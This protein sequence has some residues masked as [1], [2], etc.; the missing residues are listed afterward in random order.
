MWGRD[1]SPPPAPQPL[2]TLSKNRVGA[3]LGSPQRTP[4]QGTSSVQMGRLKL[5]E[6]EG[7]TQDHTALW[8]A[9]PGLK[10]VSCFPI[11]FLSPGHLPTADSQPA[12]EC[13]CSLLNDF[14]PSANPS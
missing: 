11:Y 10:Q 14:I 8:L 1:S 4:G 5:R 12:F 3:E 7:L 2:S 6:G 13:W 9:K